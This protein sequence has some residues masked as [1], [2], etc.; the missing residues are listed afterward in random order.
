MTN[1]E[2][3]S[4]LSEDVLAALLRH[5]YKIKVS[6]NLVA[7]VSDPSVAN[8]AAAAIVDY[9][10]GYVREVWLGNAKLHQGE[11]DKSM[12]DFNYVVKYAMG[13]KG[14]S[15]SSCDSTDRDIDGSR[16]MVDIMKRAF[17]H[18]NP[19]ITNL[20][21]KFTAL[22]SAVDCAN[23][24]KRDVENHLQELKS[25][26]L[27]LVSILDDVQ[28]FTLSSADGEHALDKLECLS[29]LYESLDEQ[30][31]EDELN[32]PLKVLGWYEDYWSSEDKLSV[33]PSVKTP[34]VTH[35]DNAFKSKSAFG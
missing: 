15:F 25:T 2:K 28:Y 5:G 22:T 30:G 27:T 32:F 24:M 13:V 11:D 1:Q 16:A 29:E 9:N 34:A 8:V 17:E 18:D 3:S 4:K 35:G 23:H 31:F 7:A 26:Y 12:S 33:A 10:F 20:L 21:A 19:L 14:R 6:D